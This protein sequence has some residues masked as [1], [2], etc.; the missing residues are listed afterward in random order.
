MKNHRWLVKAIKEHILGRATQ[1]PSAMKEEPQA[2][3]HNI[4]VQFFGEPPNWSDLDV[5]E[6]L[7]SGVSILSVTLAVSGR[8]VC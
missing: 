3:Q 8:L 1:R 5:Y 7:S 2:S 4:M 6:T